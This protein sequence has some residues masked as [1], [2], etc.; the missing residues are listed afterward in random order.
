MVKDCIQIKIAPVGEKEVSG[1]KVR[2]LN[3]QKAYKDRNF[4]WWADNEGVVLGGQ[5]IHTGDLIAWHQVFKVKEVEYHD[6]TEV[7]LYLSGEALVLFCDIHNGQVKM[8]SLTMV[9]IQPGTRIVIAKGKGHSVPIAI[10]TEPVHAVV[11]A[12][13]LKTE[14]AVLPQEVEGVTS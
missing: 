1:V 14:W 2:R 6:D 5:K 13:A 10:G 12:P 11:I 7:F 9:S 8:D 4:E 3:E